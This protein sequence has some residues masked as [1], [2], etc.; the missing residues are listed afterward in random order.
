MDVALGPTSSEVSGIVPHTLIL[1]AILVGQQTKG[2]ETVSTGCENY[3][4]VSRLMGGLA[5][6]PSPISIA[7]AN[8]TDSLTDAEIHA[9]IDAGELV[10]V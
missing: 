9:W 7:N 3:R 8:E 1:S 10:T 2:G 5:K 6:L 4:C